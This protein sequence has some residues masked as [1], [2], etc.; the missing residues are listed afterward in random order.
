MGCTLKEEAAMKDPVSFRSCILEI[1]R[2]AQ[3][4]AE[5]FVLVMVFSVLSVRAQTLSVLHTFIAGTDGAMPFAGLLLDAGNLYGT[6]EIGGPASAGTVFKLDGH[7]NE[8]LYA[9]TGGI[10]GQ[11]PSSSLIRDAAGNFYGTIFAGGSQGKGAVYTISKN[12]K[13]RILYSFKGQPDGENPYPA[14]LRDAQGNFYGTTYIGGTSGEG[15]A[16]KL[17][18]MG[19]ETVLHS[20]TGG[21]D[22]RFPYASLIM[23]DAGNLCGTTLDGGPQDLGV[24]FKLDANGNET[25]LYRFAGGEDGAY[26]FAGL[27]RDHRGN[28]YGTTFMG[29]GNGCGGQ[30]CG[31]VFKLDSSGRETVLYSFQEL[32]GAN[33]YGGL[34]HDSDGNLYGAT[35]AGGPSNAG[36][37]Y[38]LNRQ[39]QQTVL[40]SFTGGPDGAYPYATLVRD[41]AGNLYG[42]TWEGGDLTC[43][44][45]NGPYG[46]GVVFKLA[47][48]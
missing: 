38:K 40:Y 3:I 43:N 32:H 36:V 21:Q 23:D 19:T 18:A 1:T 15:V 39:G 44:N 10:N 41:T 37:V 22:G 46:C 25:V 7:G 16:F 9:F 24:V 8:A 2:C 42:T 47:P 6:T 13:E 17:D 29:G 27:F 34:I 45:P 48:E 28:L 14:L 31:T 35:L 11:L 5:A 12:G 4:G 26:P 33:P 20:F 30:G